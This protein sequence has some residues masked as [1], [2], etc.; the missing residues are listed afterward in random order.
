MLDH[1]HI[2][3]LEDRHD[4][5]FTGLHVGDSRGCWLLA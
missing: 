1:G 2:Q 4:S 3:L 5:I